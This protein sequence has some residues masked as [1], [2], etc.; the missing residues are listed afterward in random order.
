MVVEEESIQDAALR[1]VSKTDLAS[2]LAFDLEQLVGD[3]DRMRFEVKLKLI[4]ARRVDQK[5]G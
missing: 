1:L 5:P 2:G 3:L 4:E